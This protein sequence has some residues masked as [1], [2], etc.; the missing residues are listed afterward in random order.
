MRPTHFLIQDR[1]QFHVTRRV[2]INNQATYFLKQH[3]PQSVSPEQCTL[4]IKPTHQLKK[5]SICIIRRGHTKNQAN[6]PSVTE[7]PEHVS[8]EEYIVI[9]MLTYYLKMEWPGYVF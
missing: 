3:R 1:S 4:K 8:S 9:G 2:H 5:K 7:W 6:S